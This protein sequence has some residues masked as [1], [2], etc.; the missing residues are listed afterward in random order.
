MK[1]LFL[2]IITFTLNNAMAS[3]LYK[4]VFSSYDEI[5]KL[6]ISDPISDDP[7]NTELLKVYSKKKHIGFIREIATTTGCDSACLP[8]IYTSF[9]NE[10]GQ[11][12]KILSKDGLTKL[13]HMPF[14]PEDYSKLEYLLLLAPKELENI[15]NPK[16]MTDAISGATLNKFESHV[17]KYAAYSTLRIHVYNQHTIKIIKTKID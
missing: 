17:V 13:N 2:F 10:K 14:T 4:K 11:F 12:L 8:V 7:V 16:A 9:Y 1:Y 3:D 6:K 5:V 15:S